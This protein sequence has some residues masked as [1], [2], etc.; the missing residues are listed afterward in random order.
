M[1]DSASQQ[2]TEQVDD[3]LV[4]QSKSGD[5]EAMTELVRRHYPGS[6]RIARSILRSEDEAQDAVQESYRAA[7]Q[8]LHN[9]RQNACFKTWISRIVVN[10]SLMVFRR[11]R[12]VVWTS[13]EEVLTA[14]RGSLELTSGEPTQEDVLLHRESVRAAS[15][16]LS[17]LPP[18]LREAYELH[19]VAGLSVGEVAARLGLSVAA[20]KSRLFRARSFLRSR[21]SKTHSAPQA[22][23]AIQSYT[24]RQTATLQ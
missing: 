14:G 10:Q 20:T 4:T 16:A 19:E 24:C 17:R 21:L 3:R 9:F 18:S 13:L 2:I 22:R 5:R 7:F 23:S 1:A 11:S 8:H 6:L 15:H 12:R